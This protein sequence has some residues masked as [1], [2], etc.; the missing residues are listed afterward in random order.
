MRKHIAVITALSLLL[1]GCTSANTAPAENPEQAAASTAEASASQPAGTDQP[2]MGTGAEQGKRVRGQIQDILGNDVT[3]ALTEMPKRPEGTADA[4]A[5]KPKAATGDAM[6]PPAGFRNTSTVK[7]TGET[8]RIQ[9]PVGVP[10]VSRGQEGETAL[11]LSDLMTG[12]IIMVQYDTDG[13]TII[14][15]NVTAGGAQ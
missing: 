11:Q 5:Q 3:L 2:G 15:V 9:I 6:G 14:G 1:A 7:L 12:D 13:S 10:I 8:L 4:A